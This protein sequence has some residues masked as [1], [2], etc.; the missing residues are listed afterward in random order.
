MCVY[1][2]GKEREWECTLHTTGLVR[3]NSNFCGTDCPGCAWEANNL[4]RRS[5]ER[6]LHDDGPNDHGFG[7][8]F[9]SKYCTDDC[10]GCLEDWLARRGYSRSPGVAPIT[11]KAKHLFTTEEVLQELAELK[12]F[13]YR[14]CVK[15][16]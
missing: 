1:C 10:M 15:E 3:P 6:R 4:P 11:P 12:S 9:V 14:Y 16:L 5:S 13:I 8:R 7:R 2:V